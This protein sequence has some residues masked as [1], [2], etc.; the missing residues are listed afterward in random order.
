M[1]GCLCVPFSCLH[2]CTS[3]HTCTCSPRPPGCPCDQATKSFFS[4]IIASISDIS[5]SGDG[6][7]ILSR[8]Y[9]TLKL[10]DINK[11]SAPVMTYMVHEPL[12]ARVGVGA[13]VNLGG[14]GGWGPQAWTTCRVTCIDAP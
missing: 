10:W 3:S 11:E 13:S 14:V 12:R 6:R 5:F 7:Y 1:I 4:E 2:A 8:D 9:M